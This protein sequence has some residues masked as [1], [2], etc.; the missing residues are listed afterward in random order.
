MNS[1]DLR[2][3]PYGDIP[4]TPG[5]P[6]GV[7]PI[8]YDPADFD[9][10]GEA[11]GKVMALIRG[12]LDL[13]LAELAE[14][15]RVSDVS[16]LRKMERGAKPISGPIRLVLEAMADGRIDPGEELGETDEEPGQ[17]A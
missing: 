15:L 11:A 10:G 6:E 5:P 12:R 17:G 13:T 7:I 14:I 8:E 2:T 4:D 1:M 9:K 3:N 16:M